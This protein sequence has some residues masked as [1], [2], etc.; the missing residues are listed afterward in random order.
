MRSKPPPPA[1]AIA[2]LQSTPLGDAAAALALLS[3]APPTAALADRERRDHDLATPA[4][5]AAT[6]TGRKREWEEA[7]GGAAEGGALLYS[8]S[9]G[10]V[11]AGGPTPKLRGELQQRFR[12]AVAAD[13]ERRAAAAARP[14][15]PTAAEAAALELPRYPSGRNESGYK[16]VHRSNSGKWLCQVSFQ[17][18]NF[19]V[20]IFDDAA[21]AARAY[22][23]CARLCEVLRPPT[24]P[25]APISAYN[26]GAVVRRSAP[27]AAPAAA[28]P[29]PPAAAPPAPAE[30]PAP[31]ADWA[32]DAT[33]PALALLALPSQPAPRAPTPAPS[34]VVRGPSPT[35][36]FTA[37][38]TRAPT[39]APDAAAAE[40][41]A[42]PRA[43]TPTPALPPAPPPAVRLVQP[44]TQSSSATPIASDGAVAS[45]LVAPGR[46]E[47]RIDGR[48]YLQSRT[49]LAVGCTVAPSL[50]GTRLRLLLLDADG[51]PLLPQ[52]RVLEPADADA[53]VGETGAV[54]FPP[55]RITTTPYKECVPHLRLAAVHDSVDVNDVQRAVALSE[56]LHLVGKLSRSLNKAAGTQGGRYPA[57]WERN[58]AS[59]ANAAIG[60]IAEA[61]AVLGLAPAPLA[62]GAAARACDACSGKHRK[63]TCGKAQ[64]RAPPC[65]V[66]VDPAGLLAAPGRPSDADADAAALLASLANG[67]AFA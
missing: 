60:L 23:V 14:G 1:V 16:G 2:Q 65:P 52:W 59:E 56:P 54:R 36:A 26:G 48:L 39:P 22:S 35:F 33:E 28:P 63:H 29:A 25:G 19:K 15:G 42:P 30:P 18:T 45:L 43:P 41:A 58:C 32:N 7:V 20:G 49:Q 46:G 4:D 21:E 66:R 53:V 57:G 64:L 62:D 8:V 34:A 10:P 5:L 47:T 17:N 12:G 9:M 55:V 51:R 40:A 31:T 11:Q 6:A 50:A 61:D 38:P 37:P 3:P 27:V 24:P 13:A 67:F 44:R